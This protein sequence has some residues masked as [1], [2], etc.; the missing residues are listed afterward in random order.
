MNTSDPRSPERSDETQGVCPTLLNRN[1]AARLEEKIALAAKVRN[2]FKVGSQISKLRIGF[3]TQ[4]GS[5][6]GGTIQAPPACYDGGTHGNR[7]QS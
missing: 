3:E 7:S 6:I 4:L 2:V 1:G 5:I